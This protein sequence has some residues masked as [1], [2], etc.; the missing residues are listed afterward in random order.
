MQRSV[1]A[2]A[3][4]LG[5]AGCQSQRGK[6]IAAGVSAGI[7][8]YATVEIATA[9]EGEEV[10]VVM[11]ALA[12]TGGLFALG[13]L[14]SGL[15]H[16]DEERP[17]RTQDIKASDHRDEAWDY[18]KAAALAA[19]AGDCTTVLIHDRIVRELD[20]DFHATVFL[21]DVAIARC[22]VVARS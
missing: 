4:V 5:L 13:A 1:V 17:S 20:A 8:G 6:L 14:L 22:I 2:L 11:T 12:V 15:D 19:R 3:C 7:A 9:S 18:T 16:E 21:A 10:P